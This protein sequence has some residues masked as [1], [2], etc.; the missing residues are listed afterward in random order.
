MASYEKLT[1]KNW[2]VE[3]RPREK[4]LKYG[5]NALSNAELFAILIGSG[6]RTESAVE[7]SRRILLDFNND[8]SKLAKS[9]TAKLMSYNGMGEAK[10]I[11]VLSALELGKRQQLSQKTKV[12]SITCSA[13]VFD[14]V[15]LDLCD[16]DHEEF[17]VVY[18]D[19]ANKVLDTLK[20]S[21]GGI[22]GTVID[23]RIIMKNAL[24]MLASSIILVHNHPSGN[25][26]PSQADINITKKAQS[27]SQLFDVK[28][29]DHVIIAGRKFTSF[30]DDGLID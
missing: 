26:S 19:R 29:L 4:M 9:S 22:S 30:A 10:T 5:F 18:L 16:L 8:L 23:I 14:L 20:I 21:Q 17:W 7:L 2:A 15:A 27:A 3:D 28:L 24:E 13:D 25:L 11:N 12:V 1:I 6:N